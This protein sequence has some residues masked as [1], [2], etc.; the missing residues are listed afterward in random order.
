MNIAPRRP[1]GD[2]GAR[3]GGPG[4]TPM[5][6]ELARALAGELVRRADEERGLMPQARDR[7]AGA[8]REV[9]TAC[10]AG[11]AEALAVIVRR[12]AWPTTA[13]VAAP[14]STTALMILLHAPD[15]GSTNRRGA[16]P[17]ASGAA[18]ER[19]VQHAR[20]YPVRVARNDSGWARLDHR[21]RKE[22]LLATGGAAHLTLR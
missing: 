14:A 21:S 2:T 18:G 17:R 8:W 19:D 4:V 12:H 20:K 3:P 7:P 1:A 10:R 6:P 15:L 22:K 5:V 9:L 13:Q 16:C 11:D